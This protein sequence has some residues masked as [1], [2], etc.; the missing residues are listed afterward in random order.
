[1]VTKIWLRRAGKSN[2][3]LFLRTTDCNKNHVLGM[4]F[5]KASIEI[6][7]NSVF[8]YKADVVQLRLRIELKLCC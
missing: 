2:F 8:L 3:K 4:L 7:E 1:M 5:E 6:I